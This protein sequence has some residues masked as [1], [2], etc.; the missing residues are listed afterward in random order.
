MTHPVANASDWCPFN[1][2]DVDFSQKIEI[3]KFFCNF[4]VPF[5][6]SG[7]NMSLFSLDLGNTLAHVQNYAFKENW[8]STASYAVAHI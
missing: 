7:E 8:K 3:S 1:E 6:K 5:T 4:A 2:I